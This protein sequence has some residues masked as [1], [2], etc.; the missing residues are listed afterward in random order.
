MELVGSRMECLQALSSKQPAV[1]L[2]SARSVI[3]RTINP[4]EFGQRRIDLSI[5]MKLD[6]EELLA[7]LID[8]GYERQPVVSGIGDISLRG[9]IIDIASFSDD[10]PVRLELDD[11]ILVSLRRFSLV[12]QR[13]T[14]RLERV[15]ILPRMET[16]QRTALL[17]EHL[18]ENCL[19]IMDEPGEIILR[20]GRAVRGISRH[21]QR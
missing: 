12:D 2:A 19:V 10:G 4:A 6:R 5:G 17:L 9:S 14:A 3:Q 15:T 13:S 20:M 11:D 18:P 21:G 8:S 16:S 1:I 7:K